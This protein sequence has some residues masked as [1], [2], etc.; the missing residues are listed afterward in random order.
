MVFLYPKRVPLQPQHR[1]KVPGQ[2]H[3]IP[4]VWLYTLVVVS[5]REAAFI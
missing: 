3:S 5:N 4:L 1:P 2:P